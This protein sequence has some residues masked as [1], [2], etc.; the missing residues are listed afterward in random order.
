M[1]LGIGAALF[2]NIG[3]PLLR[4]LVQVPNS[5]PYIWH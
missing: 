2:Q 5:G 1:L 3:E 4:R